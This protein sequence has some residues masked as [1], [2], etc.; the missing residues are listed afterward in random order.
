MQGPTYDPR[1]SELFL[2]KMAEITCFFPLLQKKWYTWYTTVNYWFDI[3]SDAFVNFQ[4]VRGNNGKTPAGNG[5]TQACRS[6]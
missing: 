4:G 3:H 2:N 1:D 5:Q 6:W